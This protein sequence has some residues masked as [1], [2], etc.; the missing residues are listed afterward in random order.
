MPVWKTL[1]I[2]IVEKISPEIAQELGHTDV[3]VTSEYYG[4]F[5]DSD[6]QKA[7]QKYTTMG[8]TYLKN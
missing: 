1:S 5:A 2:P 6:L 8:Q 4:T 3:K 7:H